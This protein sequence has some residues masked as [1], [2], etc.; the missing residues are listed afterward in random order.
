MLLPHLVVN[1]ELVY[2]Q[3][4]NRRLKNHIKSET[5]YEF[6]NNYRTSPPLLE[7]EDTTTEN[8][9]RKSSDPKRLTDNS[10]NT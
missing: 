3:L 1:T 7:A 4:I 9:T 10:T 8:E 2:V 5:S 6:I